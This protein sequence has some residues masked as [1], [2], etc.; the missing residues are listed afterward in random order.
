MTAEKILGG[1][2]SVGL[3]KWVRAEW[4]IGLSAESLLE[5]L[6]ALGA[7]RERKGYV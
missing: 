7:V 5:N 1:K 4:R 2:V 6:C 3:G